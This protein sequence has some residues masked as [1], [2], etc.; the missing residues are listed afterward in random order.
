MI[1][2]I[3][4]IV[5]RLAANGAQSSL[6]IIEVVGFQIGNQLHRI[7][8]LLFEKSHQL[9]RLVKHLKTWVAFFRHEQ[10]D[11]IAPVEVRQPDQHV[12]AARPNVQRFFVDLM[13]A[14]RTRWDLQL[15]V[16]VVQKLG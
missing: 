7:G 8:K 13:F 10:R 16:V 6:R 11:R 14:I 15:F 12:S 1:K 5:P 3:V 2:P 4:L 9:M